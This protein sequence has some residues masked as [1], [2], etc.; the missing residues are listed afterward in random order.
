VTSYPH[1]NAGKSSSV[2]AMLEHG[3]PVITSWG[4]EIAPGIAPIVNGLGARLWRAD[5]ALEE[6]LLDP[7]PRVRVRDA[8]VPMTRRMLDELA[9]AS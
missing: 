7:P 2:A 1:Y 4:F 5:A 8:V 3:L 9:G 6:R